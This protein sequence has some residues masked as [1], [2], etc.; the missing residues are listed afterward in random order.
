M[1]FQ[2]KPRIMALVIRGILPIISMSGSSP[3]RAAMNQTMQTEAG[4]VSGA[5]AQN[6][7]IKVHGDANGKRLRWPAFDSKFSTIVEFGDRFAPI[8]VANETGLDFV[9]RF[10]LIQNAW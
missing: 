5:P 3:E 6:P 9:R 2:V 7:F 4:L 10:F 1:R 8:A